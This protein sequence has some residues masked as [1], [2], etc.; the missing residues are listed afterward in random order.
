MSAGPPAMPGHCEHGETRTK[1][2][3]GIAVFALS[4]V[5]GDCC[6]TEGPNMHSSRV[7]YPSMWAVTRIP[8]NSSVKLLQSKA[9]VDLCRI[10]GRS[11]GLSLGHNAYEEDEIR[12]FCDTFPDVATQ[13][14]ETMPALG[15]R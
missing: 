8:T 10:Q 14:A 13:L 6:P 5:L 2:S 15:E 1:N 9:C 4:L 11:S 7:R 12:R 3:H